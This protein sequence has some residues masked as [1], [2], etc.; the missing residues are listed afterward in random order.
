MK[1]W[2]V[3]DIFYFEQKGVYFIYGKITKITYDNYYRYYY[4]NIY[5]DSPKFSD[6]SRYFEEDSICDRNA[7]KLNKKEIDEL[8]VEML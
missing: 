8:M 6:E 5:S 7:K 4:S 3:G 1:K 2:E